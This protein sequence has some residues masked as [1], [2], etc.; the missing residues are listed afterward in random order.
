MIS[1][2]VSRCKRFYKIFIFPW[3]F[4]EAKV[5]RIEAQNLLTHTGAAV[6]DDVVFPYNPLLG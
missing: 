5:D 2:I 3:L 1:M 4:A 6:R